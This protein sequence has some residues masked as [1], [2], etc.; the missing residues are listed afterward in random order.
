MIDEEKLYAFL[1]DRNLVDLIER[2]KISD[3]F[4]DVITLSETQHSNMLAW[5]LNPN[6]GHAQ[7]DAVLKD[8]LTAAYNGGNATNRFA[9]KIFFETWTPVRIRTA[10]FGAAFIAREFSLQTDEENSRRRLDLFIID[11][12]NKLVVTVENKAG[13]KLGEEQLSEY[14]ERVREKIA[15]R[16]IFRDYSFLYVVVDRA[17]AN[18]DEDDL[19]ALG[20]KW[21]L[22]D[23]SWLE[24]GAKRARLHLERNNEAAQL[25]MAYCQ[26]QTGWESPNEREVSALAADLAITHETVVE[27]IVALR[28]IKPTDWKPSTF[29]GDTGQLL[30]FT[31]Q[32]DKLCDHLIQ[33]RGVGTV[34]VGLRRAL[35]GVE[36]RHFYFGRT[37]LD[38]A[39]PAMRSLV[40]DPDGRPPLH[41]NIYRDPAASDD[42]SRFTLRIFWCDENFEEPQWD[43]EKLRSYLA[44]SCP[45]LKRWANRPSRQLV[46]EKNLSA[47]AVIKLASE[48][49]QELD[50]LI[51]AAR[52]DR[53]LP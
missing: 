53:I 48:L 51:A 4:L 18:Y 33:A 49:V 6:E 52:R 24:A 39:T 27:E 40:P 30:I 13:A 38:M 31:H 15:N 10:S 16:P 37:W 25:L 32:N 42:A 2:V 22:L 23:Y 12:L 8:F 9:N 5:C 45:P 19:A 3:D 20:N 34:R 43:P 46:L 29:S 36:P 17:L 47:K 7:G 1:S 44:N 28:K 41:I 14:Y 35:P 21:A 26:H 50:R 11:P